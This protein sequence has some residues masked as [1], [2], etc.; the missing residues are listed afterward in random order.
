[1]PPTSPLITRMC[2]T[3]HTFDLV[4]P[5]SNVSPSDNPA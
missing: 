1:M 4:V 5:D 3:A 2:P